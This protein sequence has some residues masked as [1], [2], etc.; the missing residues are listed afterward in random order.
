MVTTQNLGAVLRGICH[1][2][3]I[4]EALAGLR[5]GRSILVFTA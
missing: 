5:G 3:P 4:E 2:Q 1:V